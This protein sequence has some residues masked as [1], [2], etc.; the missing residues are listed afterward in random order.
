M[1]AFKSIFLLFLFLLSVGAWGQKKLILTDDLMKAYLDISSL[2]IQSGTNQL[3]LLK[4]KDSDNAMIYYIE[5]YVDFFTLFIQEDPEKY[6]TLI[7]NRDIRLQK[8]KNSDPNSPYYLFCQAEIILQWAT[9]KLKFDDKINAA[10]DVYEAYKLLE[11]NK[12]KF[13]NFVENNK[14]LSII[15]ALAESV[16]SWVRKIMG[17]K[18][19]V[20]MGTKEISQLASHAQKTKSIFKNEIVAIYSYILFYSNNKKEEAFELFDKYQLD[21]TSS[22]LISFLK[23]TMAQKTGHNDIALKILENRPTGNEYMPFYYLDYMYGKFKLYKLDPESNIYILKFINNFKGKHYIKEAYQ[24]LAWYHIA[25]HNDRTKYKNALKLCAIRGNSLIDEDIQADK[26][27]KSH[28]VPDQIL[29]KARL[30]YDGGYYAKSHN[31]LMMNSKKF[32]IVT[33]D[34]EYYYRLARVTEALKNYADAIEYY[35]LTISKGNPKKYYGCNAA[36]Q[37]GLI[38]ETK[39]QYEEAKKYFNLCLKMDP[40]GYSNS[41]HQKAKSGLNRIGKK[42]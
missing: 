38:Y 12:E 28:E 37:L 19:S 21:A 40:A 16:P 31:L 23:A 10:R 35:K 11:K 4:L 36:L 8:I 5:N 7:K 39:K 25:I 18:G 3:N 34:G 9:I 14:S 42:Q 1:Q 20:E 2:K 17:I 13:P 33:F 22:P 41:L 30:L 24:K 26:E 27:A 15:H 29:L 32:E 6:K